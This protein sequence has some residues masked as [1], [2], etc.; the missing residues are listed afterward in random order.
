MSLLLDG[1]FLFTGDT[2]LKTSI[3]RP[4]LGGKVDEWARL[5]Y[6]SLFDRYD[7]FKDDLI[8]LPS[9]AVSV[10]EQNAEGVVRTT[11]GEARKKSD[12]Y[13]KKDYGE[14]LEFIKASLPESQERYQEI[15]KVNLGLIDPDEKT[16]KELEIWKNLCGLA[17]SF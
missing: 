5:L 14:F 9:H 2:I 10:G 15:R 13:Q 1:K 7:K 12:L 4:D 17:K 8:I 6:G 11:L 16:R 3:G